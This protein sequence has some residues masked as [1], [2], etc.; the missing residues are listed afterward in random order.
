MQEIKKANPSTAY[1]ALLRLEKTVG[2][3]FSLCVGSSPCGQLLSRVI[4]MSGC[5]T[6]QLPE[7]PVKT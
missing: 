1:Q 3:L 6:E 4:C 5:S 2:K 7:R